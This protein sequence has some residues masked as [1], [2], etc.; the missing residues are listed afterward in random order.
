MMHAFKHPDL[1]S[2]ITLCL[3]RFP[4][5]RKVQLQWKNGEEVIGWGI[6][7]SENLHIAMVL[8]AIL[9]IMLV[10]SLI[11]AVCWSIL[12]HDISG[13]FTIA[14]WITSIGAIA[15]STW[16]VWLMMV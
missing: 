14:A 7:F 10:L 4:K 13:A 11:F 2:E 8:T 15:V 3:D 5:K 1:G 9:V 6:Y 12:E 16:S